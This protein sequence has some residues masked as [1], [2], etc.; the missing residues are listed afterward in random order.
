MIALVLAA[1]LLMEQSARDT[2]AAQPAA[3]TYFACMVSAAGRKDDHMSDASTIAAAIEGD[4]Q[5]ELRAYVEALKKVVGPDMAQ[6]ADSLVGGFARTDALQA[7]LAERRL[8]ARRN[9]N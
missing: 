1:H 2:S 4:C 7:V 9:S 3:D 5:P 8:Y 6:G